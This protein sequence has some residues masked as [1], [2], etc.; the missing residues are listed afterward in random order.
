M[1]LVLFGACDG[2][3]AAQA[4]AGLVGARACD[5]A[6]LVS[7]VPDTQSCCEDVSGQW[8]LATRPELAGY[9]VHQELGTAC[10]GT[11]ADHFASCSGQACYYGP[12][13]KSRPQ[14]YPAPP[15]SG[16]PPVPPPSHVFHA[17]SDPTKCGRQAGDPQNPDL[18][19]GPE[20]Y[21]AQEAWTGVKG[22]CPFSDCNGSTPAVSL[23]VEVVA[24]AATG[25]LSS[26][27]SLIDLDGAGTNTWLFTEV[28][29]K[30]R[31][32]P[33]GAHARAV[34]TGDCVAT[35]AFGANGECM[36]NLAGGKKVT[37]TYD[38][39]PGFSCM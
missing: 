9:L 5:P 27:P 20:P 26:V 6:K 4:D 19:G 24:S 31:A 7:F 2:K 12:C 1:V 28:D 33:A 15:A 18:E 3:P 16:T 36:L 29:V 11:A 39:E 17:L 8:F 32:A 23:T 34:F 21:V 13:S 37:V 22:T 38:C 10:T 25:H 14:I 35:G 30:L